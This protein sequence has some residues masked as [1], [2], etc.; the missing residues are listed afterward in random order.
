MAQT[1]GPT[2]P[3]LHGC[4]TQCKPIMHGSSSLL[5]HATVLRDRTHRKC[6]IPTFSVL[7]L[8]YTSQPP[9]SQLRTMRRHDST[10]SCQP[11]GASAAC[12][13]DSITAFTDSKY[14]LAANSA[15]G[16]EEAGEL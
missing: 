6:Q 5:S 14:L 9:V 15:M 11:Q 4:P 7:L 1:T 10:V 16:A 2:H 13:V 12:G 8:G 3:T